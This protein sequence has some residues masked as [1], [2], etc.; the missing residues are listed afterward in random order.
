MIILTVIMMMIVMKLRVAF[1]WSSR[2]FQAQALKRKVV[3]VLVPVLCVL[4]NVAAEKECATKGD[5]PK[6]LGRF[7]VQG[8]MI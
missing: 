8:V 4:Y 1:N 6:Q 7:R 3:K 5:R 2:N